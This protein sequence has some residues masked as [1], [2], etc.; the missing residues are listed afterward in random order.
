MR[1]LFISISVIVFACIFTMQAKNLKED[2]SVEVLDTVK[3]QK[4][5]Q[6]ALMEFG[7]IAAAN[8]TTDM[9]SVFSEK[10]TYFQKETFIYA[11]KLVNRLNGK[12]AL[13][14][15]I[16]ALIGDTITKEQYRAVPL[17]AYSHFENREGFSSSLIIPMIAKTPIGNIESSLNVSCY[18]N[19]KYFRFIETVLTSSFESKNTDYYITSNLDGIML[20]NIIYH[21]NSIVEVQN[22]IVGYTRVIDSKSKKSNYDK[23]SMDRAI[24]RTSEAGKWSPFKLADY[25]LDWQ[26]ASSG[27]Y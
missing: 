26:K 17:W 16:N 27:P 14:L 13:P 4:E 3:I 11:R 6:E 21:N 20:Q 23:K 22:G 15:E 10:L 25:L 1:R 8:S 18:K 7:A 24:I 12:I 5:F 2:E 19:S 9:K